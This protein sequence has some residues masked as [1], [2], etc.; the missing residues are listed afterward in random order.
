MITNLQE[1]FRG[2]PNKISSLL[3]EIYGH[4]F[5][6]LMSENDKIWRVAGMSKRKIYISQQYFCI[7][8]KKK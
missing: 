1:M 8:G 4:R 5:F 7:G 2:S 6:P 3:F